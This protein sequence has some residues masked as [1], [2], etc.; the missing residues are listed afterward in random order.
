MYTR[1]QV[2]HHVLR[3]YVVW[4]L[5]VLVCCVFPFWLF[6]YYFL[7]LSLRTSLLF[8]GLDINNNKIYCMNMLLMWLAYY[9]YY[10]IFFFIF[11]PFVFVFFFFLLFFHFVSLHCIHYKKNLYLWIYVMG[12]RAWCVCVRFFS[13]TFTKKKRNNNEQNKT[14]VSF[15]KQNHKIYC[16]RFLDLDFSHFNFQEKKKSSIFFASKRQQFWNYPL[17]FRF[18]LSSVFYFLFFSVNKCCLYVW[19]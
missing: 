11:F 14:L 19:K 17:A 7:S 13:A 12:V 18:A 2:L 10:F 6:F 5:C 4:I 16:N 8:D 9:C 3:A 15:T 1:L